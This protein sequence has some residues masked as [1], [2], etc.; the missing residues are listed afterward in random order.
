MRAERVR[1]PPLQQKAGDLAV[2]RRLRHVHTHQIPAGGGFLAVGECAL[3]DAPWG[4]PVQH[5]HPSA[6]RK[7]GMDELG[8]WHDQGRRRASVCSSALTGAGTEA[9]SR[10]H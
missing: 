3:V 5:P 4:A 2:V 8:A 6:V 9:G 7:P 10:S 1:A